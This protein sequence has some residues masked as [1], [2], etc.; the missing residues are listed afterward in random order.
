MLGLHSFPGLFSSCASGAILSL[1]CMH[2]L[3]IAI[4]SLVVE[5]GL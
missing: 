2:R 4:I 1:L 3:L 5:H